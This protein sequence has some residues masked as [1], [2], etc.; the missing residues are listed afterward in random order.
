M[1][2]H[3]WA[4]KLA[5]KF[6]NKI[7]LYSSILGLVFKIAGVTVI[8]NAQGFG[9][10]QFRNIAIEDVKNGI[11]LIQVYDCLLI[12]MLNLLVIVT[13]KGQNAREQEE[14]GGLAI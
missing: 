11:K 13:K 2:K 4:T 7:V 6:E 12:R 1:V 9:L 3:T 5:E 8:A 14:E 10:A